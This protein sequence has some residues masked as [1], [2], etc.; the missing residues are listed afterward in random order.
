PQAAELHAAY[1]AYLCRQ[2][3]VEEA[4]QRFAALLSGWTGVT[5]DTADLPGGAGGATAYGATAAPGT[6]GF[7]ANWLVEA[8]ACHLQVG[9]L[10]V[11]QGYLERALAQA[12]RSG[13]AV[14][15]M[16]RLRQVQGDARAAREWLR[17]YL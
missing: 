2:G 6:P 9:D 10:A 1:A 3:E 11:A 4:M 17:A 7:A 13:P 5:T 14:L 8:G 12:P 15:A 16:A